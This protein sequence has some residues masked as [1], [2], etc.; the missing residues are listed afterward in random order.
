M[1]NRTAGLLVVSAFIVLMMNALSARQQKGTVDEK[2][3]KDD[4]SAIEKSSR[5]FAK[6]FEKGDAKALAAFWTARGEYHHGVGVSAVGREEIEKLFAE[7]FKEKKN[8]KVEVLIE[9]IRFPAKDLAIEEGLVRQSSAG[10]ELPTTTRYSV[11]HVREGGEWK[12]AVC[13]EWGAGQDRLEDLDWLVGTWKA[14]VGD[15]EATLT[16]TRDEKRPF[17]LGTFSRKGKGEAV[18]SGTIKIGMDPQR[19]QIRS[20]HFDD[21]GGH[22]Q[23][24]WIRD[25]NRWVLDSVGVA[26]NGMD[27]AGVDILARISNNEFTWRS[28]DRVMGNKGLPDTVPV[29]LSRVAKGK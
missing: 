26:G 7:H 29:K 10:K 17:I 24:L 15:H 16:F 18:A 19:G 21:D 8:G 23:A 14:K 25:G 11:T 28:I 5:E 9:S 1:G 6:V 13:R 22:G 4:E 12:I 27:T 3:R 20:W 2:P